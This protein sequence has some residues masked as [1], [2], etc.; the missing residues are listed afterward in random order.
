MQGIEY[1]LPVVN[2][3]LKALALS[4]PFN[5]SALQAE[6]DRLFCP[7]QEVPSPTDHC[8]RYAQCSDCACANAKPVTTLLSQVSEASEARVN[9]PTLISGP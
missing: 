9:P 8:E 6:A 2:D 5:S 4:L 7:C 1:R 3:L